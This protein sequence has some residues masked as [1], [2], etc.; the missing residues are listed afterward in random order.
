MNY[1]SLIGS[2]GSLLSGLAEREVKPPNQVI[3]AY[4]NSSG[5]RRFD[6]F[7]N[8]ISS[9][10][11]QFEEPRE[12]PAVQKQQIQSVPIVDPTIP[13][14]P[15]PVQVQTSIPPPVPYVPNSIN[16]QTS[17]IVII[18]VIIILVFLLINVWSNQKKLE[19]LMEYTLRT[20]IL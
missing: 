10:G 8:S 5:G 4:S 2:N 20:P 1:R 13:S 11:A 15:A 7:V 6:S 12:I 14:F 19:R 3:N 16:I 18:V 17:T 9:A